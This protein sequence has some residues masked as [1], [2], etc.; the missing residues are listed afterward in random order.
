MPEIVTIGYTVYN[1]TIQI[2]YEDGPHAGV[3]D[4]PCESV[5]A[6]MSELACFEALFPGIPVAKELK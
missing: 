4:L 2:V 5:E 3:I 1:R 6:M